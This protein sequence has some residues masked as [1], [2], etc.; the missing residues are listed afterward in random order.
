MNNTC[1][2]V[3]QFFELFELTEQETFDDGRVVKYYQ[4]SDLERGKEFFEFFTGQKA[5]LTQFEDSGDELI[6][7]TA[8]FVFDPQTEFTLCEATMAYTLYSYEEGFETDV[9]HCDFIIGYEE[10]ENK[11]LPNNT[12]A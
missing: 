5:D 6:R 1:I 4:T 9:E 3:N 2:M 11:I 12:V 7:F 10:I 8:G